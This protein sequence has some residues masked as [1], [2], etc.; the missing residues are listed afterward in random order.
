MSYHILKFIYFKFSDK[1]LDNLNNLIS[2][3]FGYLFRINVSKPNTILLNT[4]N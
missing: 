2:V 3:L 1:N 4:N